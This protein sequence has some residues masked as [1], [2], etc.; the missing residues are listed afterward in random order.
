MKTRT[1]M[2]L[3]VLVLV[4]IAFVCSG[5]RQAA[6]QTEEADEILTQLQSGYDF[7]NLA[8]QYDPLTGGD[9]GWFPRGYL[10]EEQIEEAA[11]SLAEGEFSPVVESLAGYH[12][13]QV[14]E[15]DAQRLLAPDAFLILKS[16]A[17]V[18]WVKIRYSESDIQILL[19]E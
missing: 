12:I 19:H 11:F 10:P 16:K 1:L 4:G 17:I 5:V 14:I 7:T 18:D 15:R 2:T 3:F 13:L 6:A 9:L 8:L